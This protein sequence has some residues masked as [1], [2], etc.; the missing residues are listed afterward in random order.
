MKNVKTN[1]YLVHL[2]NHADLSAGISLEKYWTLQFFCVRELSL[3][4]RSSDLT[5]NWSLG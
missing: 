1:F 5:Y 4:R 2:R 3:W